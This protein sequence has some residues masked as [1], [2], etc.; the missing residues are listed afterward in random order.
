MKLLCYPPLPC[1]CWG[2]ANFKQGAAAQGAG[3]I[4][5][6][7]KAGMLAA[8]STG[9][10]LKSANAFWPCWNWLHFVI[11]S[12]FSVS[13]GACSAQP[14]LWGAFHLFSSLFESCCLS[15]PPAHEQ[16]ALRLLGE[17]AKLSQAGQ[18]WTKAQIDVVYK[19]NPSRFRVFLIA[20]D[21]SVCCIR[22]FS[23]LC[24]SQLAPSNLIYNDIYFIIY[25]WH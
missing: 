4:K 10:P 2:K 11:L 16:E 1:W 9:A 12:I 20:S 24:G 7:M 13:S 6:R 22:V 18:N 21:L 25:K 15:Q 8:A 5:S 23:L 14:W 19:K 17:E 3:H